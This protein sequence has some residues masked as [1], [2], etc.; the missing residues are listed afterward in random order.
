MALHSF[1]AEFTESNFFD[2]RVY[3]MNKVDIDVPGTLLSAVELAVK[4][5]EAREARRFFVE[6]EAELF[7]VVRDEGYVQPLHV[8][9]PLHGNDQHDLDHL[10]ESG[11]SDLLVAWR[12]KY[13]PA[14][15]NPDSPTALAWRIEMHLEYLKTT[16]DV[17]LHPEWPATLEEI[18]SIARYCYQC[19]V[20]MGYVL[21]EDI[22]PVSPSCPESC[23]LDMH[24][25]CSG[26]SRVDHMID[27]EPESRYRY[28]CMRRAISELNTLH[29]QLL[30]AL[31]DIPRVTVDLAQECGFTN[32]LSSS[33]RSTINRHLI[34]LEK[35]CLA[36]RTAGKK[37]R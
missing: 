37:Q 35:R 3:I 32:K 11:K 20:D 17:A 23:L 28:D 6:N 1:P 5:H 12:D 7:K 22:T 9:R 4:D 31:S 15:L 30:I 21:P 16:D 34:D 25:A 10:C 26:W 33:D 2:L 18:Y 36:H 29:R 13:W 27:P 14:I 24:R 8:L 19:L